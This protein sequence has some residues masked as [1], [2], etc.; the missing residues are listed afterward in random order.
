MGWFGRDGCDECVTFF[1]QPT[2]G[3]TAFCKTAHIFEDG[4]PRSRDD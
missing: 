3:D 4:T 1:P 2:A